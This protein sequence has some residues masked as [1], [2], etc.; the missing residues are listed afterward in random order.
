[1]TPI[2][3]EPPPWLQPARRRVQQLVVVVAGA[4]RAA[5]HCGWDRCWP[6]AGGGMSNGMTM[7]AHARTARLTCSWGWQVSILR[8]D[9]Y[10]PVGCANAFMRSSVIFVDE[11]AEQIASVHPAWPRRVQL[12]RQGP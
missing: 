6:V 1:M 2:D 12:F 9:G 10:E 3:L 11:P 4:A 7:D 8:P 5:R